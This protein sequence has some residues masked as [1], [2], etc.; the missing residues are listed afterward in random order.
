VYKSRGIFH[1][2]A[3]LNKPPLIRKN[4][5]ALTIK[6]KPKDRAIYKVVEGLNELSP[7][8]LFA[9]VVPAK[10]KNKNMNVPM[11]S[12]TRATKSKLLSTLFSHFH[13]QPSTYDSL[14]LNSSTSSMQHVQV[15]WLSV[16]IF[17]E[18][19]LSFLDSDSSP[20]W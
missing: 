19:I 4:I 2:T 12:P 9:V 3:G 14:H 17:P 13:S 20:C 5:Q 16:S 7:G 10:A 6:L 15:L 18:Y 8:V 1:L 11:N